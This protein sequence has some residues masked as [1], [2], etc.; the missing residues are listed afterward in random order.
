MEQGKALKEQLAAMEAADEQAGNAGVPD[1]IKRDDRGA[2]KARDYKRCNAG[3][4]SPHF[5]SRKYIKQY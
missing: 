5:L 3:E 2:E 1:S 4:T